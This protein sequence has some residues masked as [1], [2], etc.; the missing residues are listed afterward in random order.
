MRKQFNS[1]AK[2]VRRVA[3]LLMAGTLLFVGCKKNAQPASNAAAAGSEPRL[4]KGSGHARVT[5]QPNVRI[6]ELEEGEKAL[7]GVSSN[8]AALLF[9]ASNATARSLKA[10]DVLVIKG[11]IARSVM[12]AEV[13]PDGVIVLTQQATIPEVI[14]EGEI[15]LEVPVRFGAPTESAAVQGSTQF[16]TTLLN[17]WSQPVYAQSPEG[18]AMS[19]A[20][21]K[22]TRDAYGNLIKAPFKALLEGW[23]VSFSAK[24]EPGKMNLDLALTKSEAGFVALLTGKGYV[25]DFD[26][27]TNIGVHQST[28]EKMETGFKKL[29]GLMNFH[30]EVAKD[31]AGVMAEESKIKLPGAIEIPLWKYLDGLPLF[32]EISSALLIHP[33]ITGGKEVSRGSFR[34][35]YDGYQ[36]FTV[37]KGNI[38]SD[39]KVNGDIQL[40]E[41]DNI[42]PTAPL[43]MV[44]S[45]AAP[46][47]ELTLGLQKIVSTKNIQKAADVVDKA[48]DAVAKKLLS[49]G[50]YNA[51]K[52][53][54]LG[55][56]SLGGTLKNALST[57]GAATVQLIGTSATSYTGMSAITPCSR[58]DLNLVGKVGVSAVAWGQNAG[59]LSKDIFRK[60][61]TRVDPPGMKLCE[62]IGKK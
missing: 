40:V 20:E 19:K 58:A 54:P 37:K 39:G 28:M 52:N 23:D 60:E 41:H 43:G 8:D 34:I 51:Y 16:S 53:G 10:G 62:D 45:F 47:I 48:A 15:T 56:F 32:L 35:S 55:K 18:T 24:P 33:A 59:S 9:D 27:S 7:I 1:E 50:G 22:G 21:Q 6:M 30:W 57:S 14:Q 29:N 3:I 25:S 11:L 61:M 42:S 49:P 44:V 12:A 2:A 4:E 46:R 26:F 13:T 5:Y 36:H 17:L 38:D 31:T